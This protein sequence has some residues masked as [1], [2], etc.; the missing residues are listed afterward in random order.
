MKKLRILYLIIILILTF[1]TVGYSSPAKTVYDTARV[2]QAW[3][4]VENLDALSS[5]EQMAKHSLVFH[6]TYPLLNVSWNPGTGKPYRGLITT[7]DRSSIAN[8]LKIRSQLKKLN[9]DI[10]LI[11]SLMYREGTYL[12]RENEGVNWWEKGHFPPESPYW[13]KDKNGKHIIGWGEDTNLNGKIDDKDTI[14]SY[15]V[16]F[17]NPAV[18]ELVSDQAKALK[19]S[20]LFDGVFLDWMGEYPTTDDASIQGWN[21][22]LSR[23]TELA[24]RVA[25]IKKIRQKT[26]DDFIIMGNMNYAKNPTLASLLNAVFMEC[27]K[28]PYNATYSHDELAQIQAAVIFNQQRLAAPALVCLEGWRIC[29]EYNPDLKTRI[30]ERN[31]PDNQRM[32]RFFTTMSLALTNGYVLFGD[33]N[34]IPL[35]DH[36]HNWY[37]FWDAPI[38]KAISEYNKSYKDIGGL[39]IREFENAWVVYNFSGKEQLIDLPSEV[40]SVSGKKTAKRFIV[41]DRDGEIFIKK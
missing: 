28:G 30:S 14:L 27:Y 18:Q 2:F 41:P 31:S 16:D 22:I 33:D 4:G 29:N 19:E 11:V 8:G 35:W 10:K 1:N 38:G 17:T 24:A 7:L 25:I 13:L 9:P 37:E 32:M 40:K 20:G 15:L 3:S 23:E 26:G 21:P 36:T 12:T 39:Y 5:Q 6:D 34:A